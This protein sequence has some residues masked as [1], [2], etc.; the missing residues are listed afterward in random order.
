[1]ALSL[2]YLVYYGGLSLYLTVK[3]APSRR[4]RATVSAG[5][6]SGPEPASAAGH[7]D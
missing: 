7:G 3:R 4:R 6:S 2:L 5:G 1:V